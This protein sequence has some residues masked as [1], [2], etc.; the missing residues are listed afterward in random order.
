MR[1]EYPAVKSPKR[2]AICIYISIYNVRVSIADGLLFGSALKNYE[3]IECIH[4]VGLR[5]QHAKFRKK[6]IPNNNI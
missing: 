5:L 2:K 3:N 6:K 1:T 4:I